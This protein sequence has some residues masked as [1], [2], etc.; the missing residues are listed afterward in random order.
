MTFRDSMDWRR[1]SGATSRSGRRRR[2]ARL[3]LAFAISQL[4]ADLADRRIGSRARE[5]VHDQ[6]AKPSTTNWCNQRPIRLLLEV[7]GDRDSLYLSRAL[8][9][10]VG[11]SGRLG[12][13][14]VPTTSLKGTT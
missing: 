12:R 6:L 13:M 11:R 7:K 1:E 4:I 8:A 2:Q 5:T 10:T 9:L 3:S 14:L